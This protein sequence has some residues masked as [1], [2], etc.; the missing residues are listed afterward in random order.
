MKTNVEINFGRA[1][2]Q[3]AEIKTRYTIDLKKA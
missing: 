1:S 3:A 2:K